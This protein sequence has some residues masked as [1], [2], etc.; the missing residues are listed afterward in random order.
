M[1]RSGKSHLTADQVDALRRRLRDLPPKPPTHR[2]AKQVVI[3]L[4][5][6][7]RA[8]LARAIP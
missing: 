2:T 5:A 4:E 3:E 6:D 1:E 7:I 8:V